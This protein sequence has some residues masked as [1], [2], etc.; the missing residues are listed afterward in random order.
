MTIE[1]K[2]LGIDVSKS[3][4][5]VHILSSYPKGGLKGYWDKT[6]NKSSSFYP[7][8]YSNPDPR[9]KQ[10]SAFDF[11]DFIKEHQPD[12]AILEPTG[13][14]YSRL[15]AKILDSLSIKIL[16]VGHIEL[17][18]YR[19]GK[20][21]PNKSDA[22]DALAMAAYPLDVEH[23]TENGELNQRYFLMHR[24]QAINQIRELCQQLEHLNRVQS[25][26]I[27]YARQLLAWQ[28]PEVA[29]TKSQST[30]LGNLPPLWG[31]LAGRQFEVSAQSWKAMENKYIASAAKHYGL[32]IDPIL[33]QHAD[34]LCDI[35][36]TEQRLESELQEL[37]A[38]EC[39]KTYNQIFSNFGFGLRVKAR[40]LSRIYPFE[41]FLHNGKPLI[42]YEVREVKRVEKERRDGQTVVK[43]LPGDIKRTKRNRSRDAFKMRLGMGTVLEQSGDELLEKPSGS[44]LCRM[45]FWQYV[46]CQVETGK[47]PE[48]D[49]STTLLDAKDNLKGI[50]DNSGKQ[51][52]N[53]KHLQ[54]K[55][56]AKV[57]N[58][59]FNQ[60][61]EAIA[62]N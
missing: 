53:G 35:E 26:I 31:W 40:L 24:P 59:L 47:L 52:L 61:V 17:R 4:V 49:I 3:S 62:N 11:A 37:L 16:W 57:A 51:M 58:L 48:N 1:L 18:R 44:A 19:G 45:S 25:P 38:L 55:L 23:H 27:N 8:F 41:A 43:R 36:L 6:R 32:T 46:L 21:L 50:T 15:W 34:W 13:N 9:K 20:N 42:E 5:T 39:F 14:H 7:V 28:F 33:R 54:G 29:H 22:A 60:L 2:T 30:K 56:M 12:V 10:K